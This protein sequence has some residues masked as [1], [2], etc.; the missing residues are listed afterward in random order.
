MKICKSYLYIHI[1]D[2]VGETKISMVLIS[3]ILMF[4]CIF[5]K[6][7]Q[8]FSKFVVLIPVIF[9]KR[10]PE[11]SNNFLKF[12]KRFRNRKNIAFLPK[13]VQNHNVDQIWPN[14]SI[15]LQK[16]C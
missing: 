12:F 1:R 8:K 10:F 3:P 16:H 9:F 5:R 15:K 7:F 4:Y 14:F 2:D 6:N 11:I 13:L